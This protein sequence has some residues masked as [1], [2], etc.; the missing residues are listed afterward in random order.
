MQRY[1]DCFTCKRNLG[2]TGGIL[3]NALNPRDQY[4]VCNYCQAVYIPEHAGFDSFGNPQWFFN[5][6]KAGRD[7]KDFIQRKRDSSKESLEL[8]KKIEEAKT[9]TQLLESLKKKK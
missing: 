7:H 8:K 4:L 1:P 3:K 9:P 5:P 2:D 6:I